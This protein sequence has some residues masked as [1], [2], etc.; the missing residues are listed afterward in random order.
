[1]FSAYEIKGKHKEKKLEK[2]WSVHW[3][4][5]GRHGSGS[6]KHGEC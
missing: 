2:R 1:M 3:T 6:P 4:V 5:A